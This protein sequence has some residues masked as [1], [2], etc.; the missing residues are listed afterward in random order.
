MAVRLIET[1][2]ASLVA[3]CVKI[4]MGRLIVQPDQKSSDILTHAD[5]DMIVFERGCISS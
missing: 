1:D 2:S 4:G 3:M 5:I